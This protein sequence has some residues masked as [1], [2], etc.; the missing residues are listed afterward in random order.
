[1]F[2]GIVASVVALLLSFDNIYVLSNLLKRLGWFEK[3]SYLFGGL[4][5]S[6]T[7][8][9]FGVALFVWLFSN[10]LFALGL[11]LLL[12]YIGWGILTGNEEA[13]IAGILQRL[14]KIVGIKA[15]WGNSRVGL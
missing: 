10:P 15:H 12:M 8:Q 5:I 2:I 1:M 14:G 3:L 13:S 11:T 6:E 7:I 9:V 4:I